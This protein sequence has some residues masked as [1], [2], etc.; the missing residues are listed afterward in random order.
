MAFGLGHFG[1]FWVIWGH[2]RSFEVILFLAQYIMR[3]SVR[4][5]LEET[6]RMDSAVRR[7]DAGRRDGR[8]SIPVTPTIRVPDLRSGYHNRN[9]NDDD[10]INNNNNN[11]QQH[12]QQQQQPTHP[13]RRSPTARWLTMGYKETLAELMT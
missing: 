11:R 2:F 10:N 13:V 12:Q 7:L 5:H 9:N 6:G 3:D 1:S 8:Q 4:R